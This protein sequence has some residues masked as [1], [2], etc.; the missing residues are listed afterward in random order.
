MAHVPTFY[1]FTIITLTPLAGYDEGGYSASI[2]LPS[3]KDDFNLNAK[4]WKHN[5]AGLANRTGNINSFGV[6]GAAFGAL[7]AYM[8]NDRLGRLRSYQAAIVIWA[9]GIFMQVFSS[10]IYG[11]LLFAR[12]WCGSGA[13]ALTVIAPMFLSEIAPAKRRGLLV[14]IY[15]VFLL[16][17]FSIGFFVNYAADIHIAPIREQYRIV[18]AT[19][20]MPMAFAFS[21]SFFMP[22]SPRWLASRG[23]R[24]ESIKVL[25]RLRGLGVEDATLLAEYELID[26]ELKHTVELKSASI[27]QIVREVFTIPSLRSRFLLSLTMQAVAQWTGGQGISYY[28]SDIFQYAGIVGTANSLISSGAYGLVKLAFTMVFALGM[29]DLLGRRRC[30]IAGLTLQCAAHV[31]LAVYFG[32]IPTS[33]KPGSHAAIASVFVYAVGWSV[34]LCTIEFIYGTELFPTRVRGF[35]YAADMFMHW[36]FQFAVVRV[37]PLQLAALDIWGAFAFWAAICAVGLVILG[38]WAPETKGVPMEMMAELFERSWWKCGRAKLS[39]PAGSE[40]DVSRERYATEDAKVTIEQT[41]KCV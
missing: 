15:M 14:S 7:I 35:C 21:A 24:Q 36:M 27:W 22:E 32:R 40:G 20:L 41:E 25:S 9:S 5:A 13:G 2:T 4:N 29:I 16:S 12:I 31:Y 26:I 39:D 28:I 23:R 17:W 10:G 18:Q 1:I 6:L 37:T 33:N 30:F 3:F 38:L 11:F 34:G 8:G 19:P